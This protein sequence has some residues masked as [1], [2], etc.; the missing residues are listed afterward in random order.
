MRFIGILNH[1]VSLL[2]PLNYEELVVRLCLSGWLL[3]TS[4]IRTGIRFLRYSIPQGQPVDVSELGC[5]NE[6]Q[7]VP[8][9]TSKNPEFPVRKFG[10]FHIGYYTKTG[11]LNSHRFSMC[12][13]GIIS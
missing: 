6:K 10:I 5:E 1:D 2:M 9:N 4:P 11:K 7:K 13:T 8:I 12:V 3:P